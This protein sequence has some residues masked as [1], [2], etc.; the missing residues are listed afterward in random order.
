MPAVFVCSLDSPAQSN[1]Q[2]GEFMK[3]R[4]YFLLTHISLIAI[5]LSLLTVSFIFY[6]G[7]EKQIFND[8]EIVAHL[9]AELDLETINEIE[10][11][12]FLKHQIRVS[13]INSEGIVIYDNNAAIGNMGNHSDREEIRAAVSNG[14]GT[15]V[16]RSDTLEKSLFYYALRAENGAIVRVA[17]ETNNIVS[18]F[19]QYMPIFMGM[20]ILLF[21]LC[22]IVARY[23]TRKL[24][25]PIERLATNLN[26]KEKIDAYSELMPFINMIYEQHEDIIKSARMRQDFT[27]NVS[28]EL[29]TPLTAISGYSELIENGMATEENTRRFA[30]EI[31]KSATRLLTLIND[32]IRLSEL[33]ATDVS[34]TFEDIQL[35]QVAET[36]VN[37]L[38]M[39]AEK[40]HVQISYSGE[41]CRVFSTKEMMEELV[42]NLCDNAI[43]YNIEGGNV[44]VSVKNQEEK[45]VLT[46]K[47]TGIGIPEKHQERIFERFYRVDKS[48]SKSTGGTGLGLAIVKHI[49]VQ[50]GAEMKL[51]S[52][53]G[54]GTEISI[55]FPRQTDV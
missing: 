22:M 28:H 25:A 36:C 15:A 37:M 29:K 9:Y 14:E 18:I 52:E 13:V 44:F 27:A 7:F 33:D 41:A 31:H 10:T 2:K 1:K 48:R 50:T 21:M 49:V 42:Y 32:I 17:R 53:P 20:V 26:E 38:Q 34:H 19:Y 16:R 3:R 35:N 12:N 11:D 45:V 23:F 39:N 24:I 47:D 51:E 54:K 43:R 55:V 46:V 4:V 8:L 6:K 30:G 40:H 5:I